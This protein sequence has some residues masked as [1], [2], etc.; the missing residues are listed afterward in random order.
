MK[1][2]I[3]QFKIGRKLIGGM[4]YYIRPVGLSIAPF[5]SDQLVKSCQSV[6]EKV[7]I[8]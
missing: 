3:I 7:E 1:F 4:F 5:W 2:Y 8:Y 6:I